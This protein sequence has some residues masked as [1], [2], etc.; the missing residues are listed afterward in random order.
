MTYG[1]S[2]LSLLTLLMLPAHLQAQTW[3]DSLDLMYDDGQGNTMPYR[4]FLPPG[5]DQ[6]GAEFPLVVYLHRSYHIG[7]DNRDTQ[8]NGSGETGRHVHI[9]PRSNRRPLGH[10][11]NIIKR[12]A[13]C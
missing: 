4:L 8:R 5:Y 1:L 2:I 7:T 6:P 13:F 3:R 11:Q 10:Q 12:Q 9:M